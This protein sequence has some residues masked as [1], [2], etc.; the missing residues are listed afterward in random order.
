MQREV[1]SVSERIDYV[2]AADPRTLRARADEGTLAEG[3]KLLLAIAAY[4]GKTRLLDNVVL[5]EDPSPI[6]TG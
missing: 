3:E 2:A 4:V 5:G 1:A 6:V